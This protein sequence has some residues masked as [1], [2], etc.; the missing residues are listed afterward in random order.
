M[1]VHISVRGGGVRKSAP[2]V[3]FF[4]NFFFTPFP[5]CNP[6]LQDSSRRGVLFSQGSR[7]SRRSSELSFSLTEV[8]RNFLLRILTLEK[9]LELNTMFEYG[10]EK[11]KN[12]RRSRSRKREVR[13]RR[14]TWEAGIRRFGPFLK[15]YWKLYWKLS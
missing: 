6:S 14:S 3:L 7:G 1:V 12:Q 5:Y 4:L 13:V 2:L 8:T 10:Q 11:K 9:V 15:L